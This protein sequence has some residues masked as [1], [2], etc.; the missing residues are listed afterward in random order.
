AI[1]DRESFGS[2]NL[3][4]RVNQ[5]TDRFGNWTLF[6]FE[7]NPLT[8][9]IGYPRWFGVDLDEL[10]RQ[11]QLLN[12]MGVYQHQQHALDYEWFQLLLGHLL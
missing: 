10:L 6:R 7:H 8:G 4:Y 5:A 1:R 12:A 2:F 11:L 3:G 9:K